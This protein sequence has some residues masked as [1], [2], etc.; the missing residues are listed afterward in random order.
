MNLQFNMVLLCVGMVVGCG[1]PA[2]LEVKSQPADST[3]PAGGVARDDQ[4]SIVAPSAGVQTVGGVTS[5]AGTVVDELPVGGLTNPGGAARPAGGAASAGQSAG[6]IGAG[7]QA[8]GAPEPGGGRP[9]AG[10]PA[11]DV[12]TGGAEVMVAGQN[13]EGGGADDHLAGQQGDL[14]NKPDP[15]PPCQVIHTPETPLSEAPGV[16]RSTLVYGGGPAYFVWA[17]DNGIHHCTMDERGAW[18]GERVLVEDTGSTITHV[19]SLRVAGTAWVAYGGPDMPIRLFQADRPAET[20]LVLGGM[21][22]TLVGRPLLAAAGNHLMVIA[23]NPEGVLAWSVIPADFVGRHVHYVASN[24]G[25]RA[26]QSAAGSQGGV[27]LRFDD[28]GQCVM[29]VGPDWSPAGNMACAFFEGE[30]FSNA[31]KTLIWTKEPRANGEFVM[32][33]DVYNVDEYSALGG[34][35]G[36]TPYLTGN[37]YRGHKPIAVSRRI[38]KPA[39]RLSDLQLT[40]V[41]HAGVW[42]SMVTWAGIGWP[43]AQTA[44]FGFV[45]AP[46]LESMGQCRDVEPET[47]CASDVDCEAQQS[48]CDGAANARHAVIVQVDV[49]GPPTIT[50]VPMIERLRFGRP[51]VLS[52]DAQCTSKPE[53]CDGV[54]QD[55]DGVTDDGLCCQRAGQSNIE[56]RFPTVGEAEQFMFTERS[57]AQHMVLYRYEDDDQ[58]MRWRGHNFAYRTDLNGERYLSIEGQSGL[59][60]FSDCNRVPRRNVSG[61]QT[62]CKNLGVNELEFEFELVAGEGAGAVT[63]GGA[64]AMIVRIPQPW[65][66]AGQWGLKWIHPTRNLKPV[67][68]TNPFVALPA[69]CDRILGMAALRRAPDEES[70]VVICPDRFL[71][72]FANSG[73]VGEYKV[74]DSGETLLD[75]FGNFAR[76]YPEDEQAAFDG[77]KAGCDLLDVACEQQCILRHLSNP[78]EVPDAPYRFPDQEWLFSSPDIGPFDQ[79]AIWSV[80]LPKLV[81]VGDAFRADVEFDVLIAVPSGNQIRFRRYEFSIA[82]DGPPVQRALP[83]ELAQQSDAEE[84]SEPITIQGFPGSPPIRIRSTENG[85]EAHALFVERNDENQDVS[86]WRPILTAPNVDQIKFSLLQELLVTSVDSGPVSG[87][88]G[89]TY[90]GLRTRKSGASINLWATSPV[91]TETRAVE[92]WWLAKLNETEDRALPFQLVQILRD[93]DDGTTWTMSSVRLSCSSP[94]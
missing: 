25:R 37:T 78:V 64:L 59:D 86:I 34:Y 9:V 47:A 83:F 21:D 27:L 15:A 40:L 1:E 65:P 32:L 23:Q 4:P 82:S 55:C 43:F 6:A 77:C 36:R 48:V 28:A 60:Q 91:H 79:Q 3:V 19:Q 42:E 61:Y 73:R 44:A 12:M 8:S 63:S 24:F 85:Q 90:Y 87:T 72:F 10:M 67:D 46:D 51:I 58:S 92:A 70:V 68:D 52:E 17:D 38:T 74:D 41:S 13:A 89:R 56:V 75:A 7:E 2:P 29:V 35:F 45:D 54:D 31:S 71:R 26:P 30:L 80:V 49:D 33:R 14:D 50:L 93:G 76:V 69:A 81:R 53:V 11:S 5:T 18:S 57:H 62:D 22:E 39:S 20:L 84:L 94:E 88:P 16:T 66:E